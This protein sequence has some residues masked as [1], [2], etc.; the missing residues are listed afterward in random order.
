MGAE[1]LILR[2]QPGADATA[3]RARAL[4]LAPA[5]APLFEVAALTWAAPKEPFDAVLLTSG[6]AAR[7]AGDG[8]T[9]FL[10][11][12]CYAVG[13][14][15]AVA[16]RAA[17]F[18]RVATGS[19]DGAAVV[20]QLADDGHRAVLHPCGADHLA[21]IHPGVRIF[22][23]PV[24][25]ATAVMALPEAARAALADSALALLHSPRAGATFAGLVG[26]LRNETRIAAISAAAADAAGAGWAAVTVADRPRDEALLELA[27][28]LCQ[29]GDAMRPSN[30]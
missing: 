4:G 17:G 3:A 2:P 25:V 18:T 7:H 21:L 20:A 10:G 22:D 15:T 23:V 12:P 11:L 14:A 27:V 5:V 13:A 26:P 29:T 1:I 24:Y 9:P 16:A 8:L 30:A 19:G 28:K 6:N